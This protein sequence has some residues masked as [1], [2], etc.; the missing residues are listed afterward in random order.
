MSGLLRIL[1][2]VFIVMAVL[3]FVR[4]IVASP[5][6]GG[7]RGPEPNEPGAARATR[8]GKLFKDPVCGTYVTSEGS[9]T[10]VHDGESVYFCSDDC[11]TKFLSS[12]E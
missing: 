5:K 7:E 8:T 6:S 4:G 12:E 9:P 2:L 3:S 11:R 1:F 10:A